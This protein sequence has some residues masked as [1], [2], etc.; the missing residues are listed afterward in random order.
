MAEYCTKTS[1]RSAGRAEGADV[2]RL[3]A[4]GALR[5]VELDLLVL[6]QGLVALGLDRRVVHEDV[7]AAVLLRN[8]AETLLGVEPLHG[9]L[10]HVLDTP[11][12]GTRAAA[13]TTRKRGGDTS[14]RPVIGDTTN[15]KRRWLQLRRR[16]TFGTCCLCCWLDS[17]KG[18]AEWCVQGV[19]V[20]DPGM[21]VPLRAGERARRGVVGYCS[22]RTARALSS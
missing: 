8:E 2:L 18:S 22:R 1:P 10:S 19:S 7:V 6:V 11:V 17:T 13:S 21:K 5:D 14:L 4:L 12:F 20:P 15:Q 16:Q 3:R 9:A